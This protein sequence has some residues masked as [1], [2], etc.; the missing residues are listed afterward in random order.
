MTEHEETAELEAEIARLRAENEALA[1]AANDTAVL[2]RP[3]P[4]HPRWRWTAA[5][6]LL[7]IAALLTPPALVGFWGR[8][9]IVDA[10]RYLD[11]VG[12]LSQS[13]QIQAA[14]ATEVSDQLLTAGAKQP[15]RGHRPA[16]PP[17]GSPRSQAGDRRC[18]RQL[19]RVVRAEVHGERPVRR[20]V[21]PGQHADPGGRGQGPQRRPD[22]RC[23]GPGRGRLPRPGRGRR[24]R[25]ASPRRP[26]AHGLRQPAHP[27][28]R[29]AARSSCSRR[30]SSTRRRRSGPSPTRSPAG[31]CRS[32]SCSTSPRSSS[33]PTVVGCCS[34]PGW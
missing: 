5:I 18:R 23:H 28:R 14:V 9:T 3:A 34:S 2:T 19:R 31:C 32:S 17:A 7:V 22:R 24:G 10:Q 20:A 6:A 11:T 13:P 25:A 12:P 26:R 16:G 4:T 29:P 30:R 15:G 8:R 21:D 1:S 27:H 33:L